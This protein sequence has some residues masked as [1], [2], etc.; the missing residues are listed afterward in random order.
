MIEKAAL[1]IDS[2]YTTPL[3]FVHITDKEILIRSVL[4]HM[5][6]LNVKAEMDQF[7]T[8]LKSLGVLDAMQANPHLFVNYF[9][10]D[11]MKQ[12]TAGILQLHKHCH[13]TKKAY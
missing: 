8:G 12:M 3:P 13:T 6:I 7:C 11:G 5:V 9:C 10:L 2:G 1:F 4:L